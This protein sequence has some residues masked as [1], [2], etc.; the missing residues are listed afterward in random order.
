MNQNRD[1]EL[2]SQDNSER[3]YRYSIDTIVRDLYLKRI[4]SSEYSLSPGA[5]VLEIGSHDGSMTKQILEYIEKI[6][7][8]EPVIELHTV[9]EEKFGH[10]VTLHSGTIENLEFSMEFD[11]IF[12]VHVLEHV[13]N[14]RESLRR[15]STW[16]KPSGILHVMVPN[17]N[18]LSRQ[19]AR[20][21]GLMNATTDVLRGEKLQ[22]HLRSYLLEDFVNDLISAGLQVKATGGILHKPLANFQLDKSLEM[23]IIDM[24]FIQ[25]LDDYA[26]TNAAEASSIFAVATQ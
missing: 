5:R 23:G 13:E 17:A 24:K 16:L 12:L 14:P 26:K 25:A 7:V 11:A 9:L 2:E 4:A 22:G 3:N 10:Q 18:A 6:D 21:M 20:N 15:I 8:L 1:F 19:L